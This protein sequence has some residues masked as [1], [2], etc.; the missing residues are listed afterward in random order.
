MKTVVANWKMNVGV[1]ESVALARASLLTL[2]GRKVIPDLV[3]CPPFVALSEVRKVVARSSANI[4]AQNMF[5]EPSGSHTGETS[6]RMLLELGV[7][8]CLIGHSERR[9]QLG[10]T[11][12]MINKKVLHALSEQ[13]TPILCVGESKEQ[14]VAG[15]ARAVV[16]AQLS[17]ALRGV[18]LHT[19]G[20]L[21]VAY[22]PV[23]AIGTNDSASVGDVIEMHRFIRSVLERI[24]PDAPAGQFSIL[25]G[26]SVDGENAYGFLREAEVD[27]VLVG[28]AS[29][30]INQFKEIVEAAAEVLEAQSA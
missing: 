5:W 14:R 12:E 17:S 29:V 7:S 11:D 3:I 26:G 13:M 15:D 25:Y 30:K 16:E 1:R 20:S 8:H 19:Q 27:G 21:F 22:E 6:S 4:G 2:R 23:W 10:E 9:V 24:F 28:S 18:R